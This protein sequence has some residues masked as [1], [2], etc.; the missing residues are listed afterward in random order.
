[1]TRLSAREM[2]AGLVDDGLGI[3][4]SRLA[5]VARPPNTPTS[6]HAPV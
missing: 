2:I 1:M 5:D 4:G 3:M 6:W